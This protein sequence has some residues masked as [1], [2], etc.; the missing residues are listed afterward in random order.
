MKKILF[1]ASILAALSGAVFVFAKIATPAADFKPAA[2]FPRDALIYVQVRDLPALVNLWNESELRRRY[3]ESAQ[4]SRFKNKHLA[5]KLAAR[6]GEIEAGLGIFPDLSFAAGLSETGAALAVYDIGKMEF[7]LIAAMSEEKILASKLF[8]MQNDFETLRLDD[9]IVVYTKEIEVDRGRQRLKIF[10]TGFE[11]R[12][13]V[14]TSEKY[15]LQT[16]AN[17]KGQTPAN[18]LSAEPAFAALAAA[19]PPHL[20]TV[21]LDQ[22]K[23]NEDWYFEHYWLIDKTENLKNLRAGMFDFEITEKKAIERRV[24]LTKET[25][26]SPKISAAAADRLGRL[27]PETAHFYRFE[28]GSANTSGQIL[29]GVLFDVNQTPGSAAARQPRKDY[30]FSDWEQSY[31]YTYLD[32]DFSAEVNEPEAAESS[33][34]ETPR[35]GFDELTK[36]VRA[37]DPA[38]SLRLFAPQIEPAPLFFENRKALLFSLQNPRGLNRAALENALALAARRQ[39][40]VDDQSGDFRWTDLAAENSQARQM[41]MPGLGWK[42]FYAARQNELIFAN[43]EEL[44]K[45]ILAAGKSPPEFSEEFDELTVI[46]LKNGRET[47]SQIFGTLE[48]DAVSG[49]GDRDD[50][51][52]AG[53]G[54]LLEVVSGVERIEIKQTSAGNLLIEEIGF[55]LGEKPAAVESGE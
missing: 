55:V 17:I 15:F 20:A 18:R 10:F 54:S 53:V 38:V 12:L 42:I 39:F 4:F 21:W 41:T 44:L 34:A 25:K 13:I 31:S 8:Q 7:V 11:G 30:Y 33:A 1:I 48:T 24:F 22:Q 35:A 19:T 52:S 27:I 14:A 29:A 2:D 51:F 3:F 49:R 32:D 47:F 16:I 36:I 46:E 43:S 28:P 45:Q 40:T 50:F 6:A 26:P 37:A 23:L 9:E 5:M